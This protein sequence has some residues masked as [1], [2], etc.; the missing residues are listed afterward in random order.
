MG[1]ENGALVGFAFKCDVAAEAFDIA[2]DQIQSHPRPRNVAGRIAPEESR[3]DVGLVLKRNADA[4]VLDFERPVVGVS[5]EPNFDGRSWGRVFDGVRNQVGGDAPEGSRVAGF[6]CPRF[7]AMKGDGVAVFG[8][9]LL[10]QHHFFDL[11]NHIHLLEIIEP[12]AFLELLKAQVVVEN[13]HQMRHPL[14]NLVQV[15]FDSID[16]VQF[17]VFRGEF[18]R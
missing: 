18:C 15:L 10:R 11:R 16:L 3:E 17:E 7:G 9:L 6:D 4:V 8:Q 13:G 12:R 14:A 1:S 5:G 2:L